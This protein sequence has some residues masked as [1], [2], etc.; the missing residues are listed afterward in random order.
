[1]AHV[2]F[3]AMRARESKRGRRNESKRHTEHCLC[4]C[5][6][7]NAVCVQADNSYENVLIGEKGESYENVVFGG[8][9]CDG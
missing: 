8:D 6:L 1:M 2:Q 4:P 9:Q 5:F 7:R 3:T